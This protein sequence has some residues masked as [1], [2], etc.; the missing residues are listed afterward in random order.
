ML[1]YSLTIFREIFLVAG[2]NDSMVK[3]EQKQLEFVRNFS[4]VF[5]IN[6]LQ[7]ISELVDEGI[8]HIERNV[9]AKIVFLDT[10]LRLA[11]LI[12]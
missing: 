4:K 11:R 12:K 2:G 7:K 6:N 8:F 10:S 9:R 1:E 3:L 5:N